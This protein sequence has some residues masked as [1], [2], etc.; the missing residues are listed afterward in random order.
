I[1]LFDFFGAAISLMLGILL[2]VILAQIWN[3][4]RRQDYIE[5]QFEWKRIIYF[6]FFYMSYM[7]LMLWKTCFPFQA[8]MIISFMATILLPVIIYFF[9]NAKERAYITSILKQ[10]KISWDKFSP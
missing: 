8:E 10:L 4:F 2:M 7:I 3:F 5:I 1:H 6:S 9:L